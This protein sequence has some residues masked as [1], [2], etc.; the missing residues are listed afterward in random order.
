MEPRSLKK[1]APAPESPSSGHDK[2]HISVSVPGP[3][4]NLTRNACSHCKVK[5]AKCD[6]NRPACG[7]CHKSG[8]ACVYEVNKRDIVQL[9]LLSDNDSARLQTLEVIFGALQD[10]TDHQ[11]SQ[12]LAQ[13]RRGDSL[14]TLASTSN[15]TGAQHP[16]AGSSIPPLV[17]IGSVSSD[18]FGEPPIEVTSQ[19]FLDLLFDRNDWLQPT[20]ST[21]FN[22]SRIPQKDT[23]DPASSSMPMTAISM[24]SHP[25]LTPPVVQEEYDFSL[26]ADHNITPPS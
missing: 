21:A 13:I 12:I 5:K 16:T 24:R 1:L 20:D 14:E 3:R 19:G 23:Q 6:G 10:G 8:D 4:R 7:R 9:Q 18:E 17:S 26:S 15:R 11:A 2:A 25:A 22:D